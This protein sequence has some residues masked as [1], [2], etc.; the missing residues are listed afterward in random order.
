MNT[1]TS[2][3]PILGLASRITPRRKTTSMKIPTRLALLLAVLAVPSGIAVIAPDATAHSYPADY[4]PGV[5]AVPWPTL[6]PG[7]PE[8]PMPRP[9]PVPPGHFYVHCGRPDVANGLNDGQF[10]QC[11]PPR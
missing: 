11:G 6:P 10:G 9:A 8:A 3:S 4:T 7:V 1:T 5:P 2:R